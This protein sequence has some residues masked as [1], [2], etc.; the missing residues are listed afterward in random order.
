MSKSFLLFSL[1]LG[2]LV[3]AGCNK[4]EN[5]APVTPPAATA[6]SAPSTAAATQAASDAINKATTAATD[7][8]DKAAAAVGDIIKSAPT[9]APAVPAIPTPDSK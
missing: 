9:T 6:P 5:P 2:G 1:A 3:I 4:D 7:A 8:K